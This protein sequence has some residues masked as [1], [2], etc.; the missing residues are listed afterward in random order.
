MREGSGHTGCPLKLCLSLD[1]HSSA[2]CSCGVQAINLESNQLT[3]T[4][5]AA[6]SQL[7]RLKF[8]QLAYNN[9]RYCAC[10][11]TACLSR[12]LPCVPSSPIK[13]FMPSAAPASLI[14]LTNWLPSWWSP[15]SRVGCHMLARVA[16]TDC[17]L[18]GLS[19][20]GKDFHMI[21]LRAQK[22]VIS[23]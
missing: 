21:L 20:T 16:Q 9:L 4:I 15:S 12:M 18:L 19:S 7:S 3:G 8:L 17:C 22:T 1:M 5:P 10:M 23:H 14:N 2:D 11:S 13:C 6:W